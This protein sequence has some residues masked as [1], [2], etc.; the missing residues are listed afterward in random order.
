[1]FDFAYAETENHAHH[2][3]DSVIIEP[4]MAK[5]IG[6][7][8]LKVEPGTIQTSVT[9]YGKVINDP[10]Q[11]SHLSARFPGIISNVYVDI[12]DE[13]K[14]GEK[15]IEIE[16]NASLTNYIIKAPIS[17]R[18]TARNAEM[19][20][21]S[22]NKVL[23]T[24]ENF[25]ELWA[26]L[27]IF[28]N[29]ISSVKPGKEVIISANDQIIK[30]TLSHLIPNEQNK[31]F[32]F[33]RAKI[34]NQNQQWV[35]GLFVKGKI[36]TQRLNANLVVVNSALQRFEGQTVVFL[37]E[38]NSYEAKPVRLGK[39]DKSYTEILSGLKLGDQYVAENSYLIKADLEK[40]NASHEH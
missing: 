37:K 24:I 12:G 25:Q 29:Q 13:V 5:T 40:S 32:I 38:Q 35:P 9:V 10:D 39:R 7:K 21:F 1:M 34:N 11:V 2:D 6:L 18:I 8:T 4:D 36:I 16:S 28:P 27:E 17:G 22:Q 14:A 3:E 33:A 26:E 15:L 20:E 19:G 31:P 30:S 23:L